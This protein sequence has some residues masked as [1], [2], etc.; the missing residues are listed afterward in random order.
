MK[1]ELSDRGFAH[2][3]DTRLGVYINNAR[4]ELDRMFF[5]PWREASAT[6]TAPLTIADLGVVE[7]VVD[8]NTD[9]PLRKADY[10]S[11]L[12]SF[13]DLS[14]VGTPS[15]YYIAW[16]SG[17]PVVATYPDT[18]GSIGVQYWKVTADLT[19]VQTPAS[20]AEAHY[21][22]VD[23]AVRRAYRDS[24]NHAA[25]EAL[26]SEID[27]AIGELLVQYPPGIADGPDAYVGYSGSSVDD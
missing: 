13:G 14:I 4:A 27:R 15:F 11:L 12:E 8:S 24:D 10:R 9:L 1:T 17:S 25:S 18:S 21:T 2:L 5:W 7:A 23:L 3:S 20:P 19:G 26:Q 16:P 22:I 6:G